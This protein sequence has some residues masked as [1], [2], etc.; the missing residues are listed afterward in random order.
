MVLEQLLPQWHKT[1]W[2][3]QGG[4]RDRCTPK[5]SGDLD[6]EAMQE[7]IL[8]TDI[9]V[10]RVEEP[11]LFSLCD[12]STWRIF[13]QFSRQYPQ[14]SIR[15]PSLPGLPTFAKVQHTCLL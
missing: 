6:A 11:S 2:D 4:H 5:E 3:N 7:G 15:Q 14:G 8:L 12:G 9:F 13:S 10:L 1:V